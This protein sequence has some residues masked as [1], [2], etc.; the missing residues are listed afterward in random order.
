[1]RALLFVGIALLILGIASLF[2]TIPHRETQGVKIGDAQFGIQ[3]Q[4]SE[5]I[6]VPVSVALIV[7]GVVLVAVGARSRA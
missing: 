7:G 1:M 2:V 4:T 5:R 6:P 3:T